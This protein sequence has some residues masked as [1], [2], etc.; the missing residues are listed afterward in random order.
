MIDEM[1]TM[2]PI[3]EDYEGKY[4]RV[5][6][7]KRCWKKANI[8]PVSSECDINNDVG[9]SYVSISRKTLNKDDC[10]NI[11][12]LLEIFSV[13]AKE[14]GVN[15][16]LQAHGLKVSLVSYGSFTKAEIMAM[17]ENWIQV[18]DCP[19]IIDA[20]VDEAIEIF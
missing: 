15:V 18:E 17:S 12:N 14:P 9:R 2:K 4:S 6:G 13:N 7:I 10:D 8:L 19:D 20:E 5:D 3:L 11:C 1:R 16:F